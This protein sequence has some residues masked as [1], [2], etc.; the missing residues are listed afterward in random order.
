MNF[1]FLTPL[2]VGLDKR[3]GTVSKRALDA[4][5]ANEEVSAGGQ[6][7][8]EVSHKSVLEA[9]QADQEISL[10]SESFAGAAEAGLVE[11]IDAEQPTLTPLG[12]YLLGSG[13]S[14]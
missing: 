2:S 10:D 14:D 11:R 5:I 8:D 6:P 3:V 13:S 9:V 7:T 12:E 1:G 4:A